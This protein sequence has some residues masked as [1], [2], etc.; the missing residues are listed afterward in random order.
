MSRTII[1]SM[2][3]LKLICVLIVIRSATP[4]LVPPFVTHGL[5]SLY[6]QDLTLMQDFPISSVCLASISQIQERL[7]TGEAWPHFF[8]DSTSSAPSG[9]LVG[10]VT[11][12]GDYDSC[13]Y[14]ETPTDFQHPAFSGKFCMA[15][16]VPRKGSALDQLLGNDVPALGFFNLTLAVCMP[17]T[18]SEEDIKAFLSSSYVNDKLQLIHVNGEKMACDTKY[19]VSWEYRLKNLIPSQVV[20]LAFLV[21]FVFVQIFISLFFR[22]DKERRLHPILKS[23]SISRNL[24]GLFRRRASKRTFYIDYFKVFMIFMGIGA[25]CMLC[26]DKTIPIVTLRKSSVFDKLL[27]YSPSFHF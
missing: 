2:L 20:S 6:D 21:I 25:H 8:P 26:L 7:S 22:N 13:L 14:A 17:S 15:E 5:K 10:T 19:S 12:F 9:L 1:L 16:F 18:C 27:H 11:D 4:S 23:L 24:Y 3:H